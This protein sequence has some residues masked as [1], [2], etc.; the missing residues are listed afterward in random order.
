MITATSRKKKEAEAW[1]T[2]LDPSVVEMVLEGPSRK[3]I[4]RERNP[5]KSHLLCLPQELRDLI[6]N[7][8]F[9]DDSELQVWHPLTRVSRSTRI[10][11]T[12]TLIA[13]ITESETHL[14]FRLKEDSARYN[15][16]WWKQCSA[17]HCLDHQRDRTLRPSEFWHN[18]PEGVRR[19]VTCCYD[20]S[21][22]L[23]LTVPS[24]DGTIVA[25]RAAFYANKSWY[26][27]VRGRDFDLD[28]SG[29]I[30]YTWLEKTASTRWITCE[31]SEESLSDVPGPSV[32]TSSP[33]GWRRCSCCP[34]GFA[35]NMF[36]K[37]VASWPA[38]ITLSPLIWINRA[39]A[40]FFGSCRF[41][42]KQPQT[43]WDHLFAQIR[44][45]R[46]LRA[47]DNINH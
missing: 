42:T 39:V 25:A 9:D 16:C 22:R 23:Q 17:E 3:V 27:K 37:R 8:L 14:H 36:M 21:F 13:K 12:R 43:C 18:P 6:Y 40:G 32:C 47:R 2:I 10:D 29:H 19:I 46:Q 4:F 5:K 38:D 20:E 44:L 34:R 41:A 11:A 1:A 15:T 33:H 31:R 45:L 35:P 26:L 30:I 7:H 28:P 24:H